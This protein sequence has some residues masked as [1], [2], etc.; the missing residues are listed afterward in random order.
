MKLLSSLLLIINPLSGFLI[1]GSLLVYP[2]YWNLVHIASL[3]T[4]VVLVL[5]FYFHTHKQEMADYEAWYQEFKDHHTY[6]GTETYLFGN[7]AEQWR[8]DE[9]GETV[10]LFI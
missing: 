3:A 2:W 10:E 7:Q 6:I 4:I 9:T 1:V 5:K 8:N